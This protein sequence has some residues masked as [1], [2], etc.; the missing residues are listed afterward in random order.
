MPTFLN[1]APKAYHN[2]K[3]LNSPGGR[4][5]RILTEY[6]EPLERFKK[7]KISHTI[8]FFGSARILPK[9][10]AKAKLALVKKKVAL[11]LIIKQEEIN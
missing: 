9:K 1:K 4:P 2:L 10:E 6:T 3:F 7:F 11:I 8:V 5:L